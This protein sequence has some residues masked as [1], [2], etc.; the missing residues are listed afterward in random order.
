MLRSMPHFSDKILSTD[1]SKYTHL[2][3]DSGIAAAYGSAR[4]NR[5]LERADMDRYVYAVNYVAQRSELFF[6]FRKFP[7]IVTAVSKRSFDKMTKDDLEKYALNA[8]LTAL[9]LYISGRVEV[10]IGD[11]PALVKADSFVVLPVQQSMKLELYK[12]YRENSKSI[13]EFARQ[14]EK[15]ETATRRLLKLSHQSWPTEIEA[16]MKIFGKRLVH[17]WDI[18]PDQAIIS[19]ARSRI[20][21]QAGPR[22]S[23]NV[24]SPAA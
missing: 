1:F 3:V 24:E 7:E 6:R 9:Q 21:A 5:G 2:C 10:P 11:N 12:V 19:Q 8:V 16:A 23:R 22:R 4:V 20:A 17:G 18:E 13:S 14:L 15:S